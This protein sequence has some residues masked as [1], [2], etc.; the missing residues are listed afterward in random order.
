MKILKKIKKNIKIQLIAI[1]IIILNL[2]LI[3]NFEL[4]LIINT[5]IILSTTL[6]SEYGL[7]KLF[8]TRK[9]LDSALITWLL[10]S[11]IILFLWGIYSYITSFIVSFIAILLK[12]ISKKY[13][14]DTLNPVVFGFIW[15]YIISL[16]IWS[17]FYPIAW[18]PGASFWLVPWVDLLLVLIVLFWIHLTLKVRKLPLI[19]TFLL[20]FVIFNFF[21]LIIYSFQSDFQFIDKL[22]SILLILINSTLY[23]FLFFMVTDIKTS[24]IKKTQQI[25]WWIFLWLCLTLTI[26]FWLEYSYLISL[27][28][29]N[30]FVYFI[31]KTKY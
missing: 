27:G 29:Y 17:N 24:A 15:W 19:A 16:I 23:F 18:W 4:W 28:F 12:F 6:L 14:W 31:K 1:L 30:I 3:K 5:L 10:I 13:F 2:F 9:T 8:K 7:S 21:A 22:N 25:Y 26:N 11:V 20:S